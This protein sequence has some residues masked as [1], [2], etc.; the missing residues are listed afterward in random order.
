MSITL[1]TLGNMLL[2]CVERGGALCFVHWP[3]GLWMYAGQKDCGCILVKRIVGV[4]WSK[5]LWFYTGQRR[6]DQGTQNMLMWKFCRLVIDV[7][8][9]RLVIDVEFCRLV[10][11]ADFSL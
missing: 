1:I 4:Y 11:S 5:G 9:C 2:L 7:E 8:F 3:K 10:K 6:S